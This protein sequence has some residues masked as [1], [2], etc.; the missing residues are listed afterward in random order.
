MLAVARVPRENFRQTYILKER[1]GLEEGAAQALH[2]AEQPEA[3]ERLRKGSVLHRPDAAAMIGKRVER[4]M[5]G[6]ER[7][8]PPS[9]EQVGLHQALGDGAGAIGR[10]DPR[11]Q[12]VAGIGTDRAHLSPL[13]IKRHAV[14]LLALHPEGLV[15]APLEFCGLVEQ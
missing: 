15:E 7:A 4:G 8:N 11:S 14:E 12:A 6:R 5:L 3:Y 9:A 2:F 13:T 10:D 1:G